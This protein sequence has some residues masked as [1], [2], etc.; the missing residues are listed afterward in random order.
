MFAVT[1]GSISSTRRWRVGAGVV[2]AVLGRPS[3]WWTA[4]RVVRRLVPTRWWTRP[5]FLP[6]PSRAYLRFRKEAYYGDARAAFRADD[7]LKYL[8]WVREWRS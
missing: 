6:A 7:V 3:L 5:P 4:A 8:T 2:A 1:G